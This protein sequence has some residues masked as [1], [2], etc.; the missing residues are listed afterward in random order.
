MRVS[1]THDTAGFQKRDL[2]LDRWGASS[3]RKE[4][5]DTELKT[6]ADKV[7]LQQGK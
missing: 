3:S 5:P 2:T 1:A 7:H 4:E 6:P